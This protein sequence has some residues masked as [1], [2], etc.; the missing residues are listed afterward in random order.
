MSDAPGP[1]PTR[2]LGLTAERTEIAWGRSGLAIVAC[3]A[4]VLRRVP[5]SSQFANVAI[6][7]VLVSMVAAPAM[8]LRRR[9]AHDRGIAPWEERRRQ[10]RD[11]ALL[12][13][14][15]GAVCLVVVALERA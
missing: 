9:R 5:T 11:L 7:F 15:V 4:A 8:V 2:D 13:S 1:D 6:A 14:L 12:S 3:A 10:L